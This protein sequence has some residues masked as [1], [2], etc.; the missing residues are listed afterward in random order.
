MVAGKFLNEIGLDKPNNSPFPTLVDVPLP[1][2]QGNPLQLRIS[3]KDHGLVLRGILQDER[4]GEKGEWNSITH[5][6]LNY[7]ME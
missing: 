1:W 5:F 4:L 6:S 7:C 3:A 2:Y